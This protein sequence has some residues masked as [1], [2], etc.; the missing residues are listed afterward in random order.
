MARHLV[1]QHEGVPAGDAALDDLRL[2][3]SELVANAYLHGQGRIWLKLHR[4]SGRIRVEVIDEGDGA[5]LCVAPA[6]TTSGGYGLKIVEKLASAW[7][8]HDGTTTS[9]PR[10][11][12]G[13]NEGGGA[14]TLLAADRGEGRSASTC[15]VSSVRMSRRDA[16]IARARAWSARLRAERAAT[17]A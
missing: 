10:C 12:C 6:P 3:V 11:P 14:H 2:I 9:G 7:G 5:A 4:G 1:E 17:P 15:S 8:A 13:R 16:P